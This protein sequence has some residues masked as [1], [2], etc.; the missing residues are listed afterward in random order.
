MGGGGGLFHDPHYPKLDRVL[1]HIAMGMVPVV[2]L[3]QT[4]KAYIYSGAREEQ[5]TSRVAT[6]I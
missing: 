2:L 3:A 1:L 5:G 4:V 6:I